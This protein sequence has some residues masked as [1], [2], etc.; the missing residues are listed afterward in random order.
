VE[1][2]K[3]KVEPERPK[4]VEAP[5][6][7]VVVPPVESSLAPKPAKAPEPAAQA[8]DTKTAEAHNQRGRELLKEQ[9]YPEAIQELTAAIDAN[10]GFS[11]AY[12]ARG[13]ARYMSKDYKN[14]L[15]DLDEAIRLNPNYLNAYQ[16]RALVRKATGDAAGAVADQ[17][18][19][20]QTGGK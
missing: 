12:N 16:N 10:P 2:D 13:F 7:A 5:R 20:K 1:P 4:E 17:A 15:A 14:A 19:A 18:R 9:K 8:K 6:V 11:L 3:P